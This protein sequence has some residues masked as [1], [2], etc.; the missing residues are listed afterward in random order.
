MVWLAN[1]F[2]QLAG[3]VLTWFGLQLSKKTVF[4][5]A[6]VSAFLALTS[7]MVLAVKGLAVGIIYAI[8]A[9]AGSIGMLLP[10]NLAVCIGAL[11]SARVAVWIYRYHV[12]TLKLVSY[13]T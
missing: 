1:F 7:A 13:I 11:V 10:S 8:P 5:T 9:W 4:A 12:E 2:V 6:A 3:S